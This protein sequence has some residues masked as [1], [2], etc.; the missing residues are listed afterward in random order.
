MII[1][2]S[3][4]KRESYKSKNKQNIILINISIFFLFLLMTFLM[5]WSIVLG[6]NVMIGDIYAAEYPFQV[7]A[8]EAISHHTFLFQRMSYKVK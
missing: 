1:K 4:S 2:N 7:L 6:E 5:H 8:S 3:E